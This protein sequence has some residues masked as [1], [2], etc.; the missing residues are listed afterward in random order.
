M[1]FRARA[2]SSR[3]CAICF[4]LV[5]GL[6]FV[7]AVRAADFSVTAPGFFYSMSSNGVALSGQ[8]PT[9]TLVRGKTYTFAI[10]TS[11]S[12]PFRI[13]GA[14]AGSVTNNNIFLGTLTF[15][16]PTNAATYTYICSIHFF[17]GTINTIAP[18]A[19]TP[20]VIRIGDLA[21]GANIVL[22]SSGTNNWTVIPE[23]V[24]NIVSTNWVPLTVQSN[25]FA[26]GTN[27]TICG[28][29]P[30]NPVFIRIRSTAN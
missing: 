7:S 15:V 4:G 18:P 21:V 22:R 19:P 12:H 30:E 24:T 3:P 2:F 8:N 17:G 11:S 10:N 25:F 27:E 14:P 28:K 23:Y 9:L 5:A 26:N 6:V 29:P 16:V 13:D 1:N 20:P